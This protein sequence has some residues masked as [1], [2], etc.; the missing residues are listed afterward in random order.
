MLNLLI[1][2]QN[3]LSSIFLLEYYKSQINLKIADLL[4]IQAVNNIKEIKLTEVVLKYIENFR[5]YK[6]T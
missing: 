3:L 4:T 5:F 6:S 2:S 1:L